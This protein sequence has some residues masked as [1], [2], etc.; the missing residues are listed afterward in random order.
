MKNSQNNKIAQKSIFF[1]L[2]A[3]VCC[4]ISS[5]AQESNRPGGCESPRPGKPENTDGTR[6]TS[7]WENPYEK[8]KQ[9]QGDKD[10]I[11]FIPGINK[12]E[13]Y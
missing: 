10:Q 3:C 12:K 8:N 2:L 7:C 4:V 1:T 5:F 6:S 11:V 13:I 9:E